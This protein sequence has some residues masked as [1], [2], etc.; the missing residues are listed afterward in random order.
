MFPRIGIDRFHTPHVSL[1]DEYNMSL[2]YLHL[3]GKIY[4]GML[5]DGDY[6]NEKFVNFMCVELWTRLSD[7]SYTRI[8][9]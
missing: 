1:S 9:Q 5:N 8:F 6:P 3:H 4:G 2:I 7:F